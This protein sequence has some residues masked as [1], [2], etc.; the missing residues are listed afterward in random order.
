[1]KQTISNLMKQALESM[2]PGVNT[3]ACQINEAL[4]PGAVV[5][6]TMNDVAKILYIIRDQKQTECT[7]LCNKQRSPEEEEQH[8]DLHTVIEFLDK[9]VWKQVRYQLGNKNYDIFDDYGLRD[10]WQIV[11]SCRSDD[12]L[13]GEHE[14]AS[15]LSVFNIFMDQLAE[16]M[17]NIPKEHLIDNPISE[18]E[19]GL[20]E[21]TDYEKAL[22]LVHEK[23]ADEHNALIDQFGG[24]KNHDKLFRLA[25]LSELAALFFD[26]EVKLRLGLASFKKFDG[27]GLRDNWQIVGVKSDMPEFM[28]M[29][30]LGG[31]LVMAAMM[32]AFEED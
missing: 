5:L 25:I 9:S 7:I 17:L 31:A 8:F 12:N 29:G 6:G 13:S 10:G 19:E 11:G 27:I 15:D 18:E 2:L 14:Q 24:D 32:R 28:R 1:M 3:M 30:S 20:G 21:L 22:V 4:E 23:A 26:Q 16:M